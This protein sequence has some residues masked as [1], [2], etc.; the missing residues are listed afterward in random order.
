MHGRNTCSPPVIRAITHDSVI[1][2]YGAPAVAAI[3]RKRDP[4]LPI[5]HWWIIEPVA[6]AMFT[7]SQLSEHPELAF[8]GVR[9]TGNENDLFAS[10]HAIE[11]FIARV[12]THRRS[13]FSRYGI[14]PVDVLLTIT[15]H[16]A[17][18]KR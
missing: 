5:R 11:S 6:Q 7:A 18:S 3:K 9:G 2:H 1:E 13:T 12:N 8:A 10:A 17:F 15:W 16:S 14:D 4:D